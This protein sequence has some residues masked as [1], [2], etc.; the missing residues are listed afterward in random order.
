MERQ[1]CGALLS[2]AGKELQRLDETNDRFR[3]A[4]QNSPGIFIPPVR[5]P[6]WS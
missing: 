6:S 1:A 5:P 4:G 2:D 3:E